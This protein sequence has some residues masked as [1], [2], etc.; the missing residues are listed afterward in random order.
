MATTSFSL[1][2]TIVQYIWI[3]ISKS[4]TKAHFYECVKVNGSYSWEEI[5]VQT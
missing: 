2:G 3:S 5:I 4:Y 1:E